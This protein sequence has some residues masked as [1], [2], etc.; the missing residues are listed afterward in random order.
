MLDKFNSCRDVR[1]IQLL[2]HRSLDLQRPERTP[3]RTADC[4]VEQL[5]LTEPLDG[6]SVGQEIVLL[7]RIIG[8]GTRLAGM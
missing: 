1:K 4:R 5:C 3:E 2:L 7:G 8:R 6:R